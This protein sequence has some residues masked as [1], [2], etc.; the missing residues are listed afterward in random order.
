[1]TGILPVDD[2]LILALIF[3]VAVFAGVVKGIVGFAMP[4]LL[5]SGLSSLISPEIALSAMI[6]PTLVTNVWQAFR[7]GLAAALSTVDQHGKFLISGGILLAISAQFVPYINATI[8][9]T[10]LGGFISGFAALQ[11][12]GWQPK[13]RKD[14]HTGTYFIGG[15]A[16]AIGGFSGVWGPPTVAYLSA[17][18][19]TKHEHIRAQG[20]IYALGAVALT[21]AHSFS[22][23][24]SVQSAPFSILLVVPAL[25][26]VSVGFAIQD[27]INQVVFKR[28]TLIVLL[29]AGLNL[30]RRGL[31]G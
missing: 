9:L 15:L 30:L 18:G 16:G 28:A 4:T 11:L 27:R 19:G 7:Q 26:G 2:P 21:C 20:V 12:I 3:V 22:G 8:M 24:F 10:L 23:V 29:V 5:I 6:A 25:L 13:L 1:M 31:F 17:L 14:S